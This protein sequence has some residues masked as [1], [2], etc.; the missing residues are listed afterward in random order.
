MS[1]E[2]TMVCLYRCRKCG[3]RLF[4]KDAPSHT[5]RHGLDARKWRSFFIRGKRDTWSRPGM[6]HK[7]LNHGRTKKRQNIRFGQAEK[8]AAMKPAKP[9]KP[10]PPAPK[11]APQPRRR[12]ELQVDHSSPQLSLF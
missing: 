4:E 11:P 9:A 6:H 1:K 10:A 3:V 5:E 8:P 2:A 12:P 7:P